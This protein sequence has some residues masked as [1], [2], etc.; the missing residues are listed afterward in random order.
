[1]AKYKSKKKKKNIASGIKGT[2]TLP[3]SPPPPSPL[4]D[5]E[6]RDKV[7]KVIGQLV[8]VLLVM[9]VMIWG[10]A[11]Y[12]QQKFYADG[13]VALAAK[14]YKDA[15]TG[16][17]WAIRMYTPFSGKVKDSCEKLWFIGN[18]Y[19]K[20]GKL[21]WALITYRSLRSSIYAIKSFYMPYK[22]WIPKTD[23]KI[24]KILEVQKRREMMQLERRS[25]QTGSK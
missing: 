24:A 19:E 14:N 20:Q 13:E 18:E 12:S 4:R 16:Y 2:E 11:Y 9:F 3:P 5:K 10:R 6:T 17:E 8:A 1:M 7:L 15:T 22:E 21:D 23:A 25:P